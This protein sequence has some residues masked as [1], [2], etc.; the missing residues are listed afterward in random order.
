[1]AGKSMSRSP[2][3]TCSARVTAL[4]ATPA[5]P[6]TT[7]LVTPVATVTATVT[8]VG[9]GMPPG[10]GMLRQPVIETPRQPVTEMRTPHATANRPVTRIVVAAARPLPPQHMPVTA[11]IVSQRLRPRLAI[12]NTVTR[13]HSDQMTGMLRTL[14]TATMIQQTLEDTMHTMIVT[15]ALLHL[16][17]LGLV[18]APRLPAA[19]PLQ[20]VSTIAPGAMHRLMMDRPLATAVSRPVTIHE[21]QLAT[22]LTALT[23][24]A[25]R[26]APRPAP[27][28]VDRS[29][30][31]TTVLLRLQTAASTES[32]VT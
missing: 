26:P 32:P 14:T 12:E 10:I 23:G 1:M 28:R 5:T 8:A 20:P 3:T 19:H 16:V 11:M 22:A 6:A 2:T 29:R 27:H 4:P 9:M 18:L 25:P 31:G 24:P 15:V 30:V 13:T 7:P 17:H 21:P